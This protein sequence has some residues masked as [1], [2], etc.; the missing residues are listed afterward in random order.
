MKRSLDAYILKDLPAKMVV[1]TGPRQ[2][3]KTT[4]CRQLME[5]FRAYTTSYF[6]SCRPIEAWPGSSRQRRF[7]I[8]YGPV[9]L[10][11]P[12]EERGGRRG[13]GGD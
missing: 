6:G 12:H 3:G 1:L 7:L 4:L 10:S 13:L 11:V 2:V 5:G 9:R 8:G